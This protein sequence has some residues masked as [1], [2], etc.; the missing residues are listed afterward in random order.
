MCERQISSYWIATAA[1][2]QRDRNKHAHRVDRE[3]AAW[4]ALSEPERIAAEERHYGRSFPQIKSASPDG[5]KLWSS[6]GHR[7][8]KDD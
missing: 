2:V 4:A 5:R 7:S 3:L 6:E 8:K 1:A